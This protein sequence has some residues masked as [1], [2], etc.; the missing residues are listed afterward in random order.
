[1]RVQRNRVQLRQ[2]KMY[3][4]LRDTG[5]AP[6]FMFEGYW[7]YWIT[8]FVWRNVRPGQVALDLGANHGY[9]TLLLVDLVG[10]G[11]K[12]HAF[13]PNPRLAELLDMNIALNGFWRTARARAEAVGTGPVV[14]AVPARRRTWWCPCAT[15]R[16]PTW[17]RRNGASRRTWTRPASRFMRCP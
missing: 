12:V 9:Y 6:H 2:Y 5:F 14:V 11:G 3:V 1:M 13:E 7:E 17:C 10:P 16:T 15:R 8:E 4:D